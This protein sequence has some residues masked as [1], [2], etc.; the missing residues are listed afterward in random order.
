[1]GRCRGRAPVGFTGRMA[2]GWGRGWSVVAVLV[3]ALPLAACS[4]SSGEATPYTGTLLT[5][6]PPTTGLD[7]ETTTTEAPRATTTAPDAVPDPGA[8]G[9]PRVLFVGDSLTYGALRFLKARFEGAGAEV[10]YVGAPGTSILSGGSWWVVELA[11]QLEA[12]SPDVVVFED[13]CNYDGGDAGY[14]LADGRI[15]HRNT[16]L[17]FAAWKE[18]A[19]D[20]IA[21]VRAAGATPY[22]VITPASGADRPAAETLRLERFNA[23]SAT[24]DVERI[25]WREALTPG[26]RYRS[27]MEVDG[28][29]TR[30]RKA[31]ELHFEVGGNEVVTEV[32]WAA[33]AD[34]LG[35]VDR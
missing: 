25:D 18:V 11:E 10:R 21:R 8:D 4:G 34:E 31:D 12:W 6:T 33:L 22:W 28:V 1:M 35:L 16:R 26:G 29:R 17:M 30:V 9:V 19:A 3:A 13:C 7:D 5:S 15:A 27:E 14:T 24:L 23:L 20:A 2:V 32:T